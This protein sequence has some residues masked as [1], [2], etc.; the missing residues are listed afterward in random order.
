MKTVSVCLDGVQTYAL[1]TKIVK[2][3]V[4]LISA[5]VIAHTS[6]H[7]VVK[8]KKKPINILEGLENSQLRKLKYSA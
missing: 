1:E 2:I 4:I 3:R 5:P 8:V 6:G 7:Q